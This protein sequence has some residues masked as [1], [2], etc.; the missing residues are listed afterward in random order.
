MMILVMVLF[1]LKEA[2][3]MTIDQTQVEYSS[4]LVYNN[5]LIWL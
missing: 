1:L 5:N 4:L 2:K 3:T